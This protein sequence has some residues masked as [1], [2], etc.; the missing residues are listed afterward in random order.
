MM[1]EHPWEQ[2]LLFDS[3]FGC[4]SFYVKWTCYQLLSEITNSDPSSLSFLLLLLF[5]ILVLLLLPCAPLAALLLLL[6]LIYILY[7]IQSIEV[8]H[9]FH[10]AAVSLVI[11]LG[12]A[13]PFPPKPLGLSATRRCAAVSWIRWQRDHQTCWKKDPL[14][15]N[16]NPNKIPLKHWYNLIEDPESVKNFRSKYHPSFFVG[17]IFIKS[18]LFELSMP[19][20]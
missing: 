14:N 13:A 12:S 16:I 8:W 3:S 11:L 6:L 10:A 1:I 5:L 4:T 19:W 15:I 9:H 18:Q 2:F 17:R 20:I 7:V